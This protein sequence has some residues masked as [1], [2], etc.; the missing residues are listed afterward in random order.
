MY[1]YRILVLADIHGNTKAVSKLLTTIQESKIK[2]D[3][4]LIAGDLPE[5]TPIRLILQ[6]ILTHG[7]LSK[8]KYTH[9]VYKGRGR[10]QF[11][12]A[13]I[14]SVKTILTLLGSLK[15]PIVYIP[16]NVDSYE[17]QRL[18]KTWPNTKI[19]FLCTTRKKFSN[20]QIAG[21][22]GSE[23][24]PIQYNIP[25][26][27]MEFHPNDFYS[28]L[29]PILRKKRDIKKST[30]DILVTHEAPAFQ[31]EIEGKIRKGGSTSI[32]K[33]INHM[34]PRIS[35][36]GHY[37]ELPTIKKWKNTIYLNPGPL[38]CYY[39]SLIDIEGS[40][41]RVSSKKMIPVRNDYKNIIYYYRLLKTKMNNNLVF[42]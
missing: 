19:S 37:H 22:G 27:D 42:I 11:V 18:L 4:I 15:A 7:N 6:Y 13:Q 2:V 28:R 25:L 21:Y 38:T 12:H 33:L 23:F 40:R 35:I 41:V 29:K 10:K 36:F 17:V 24:I 31:Y 34:K 5:T 1:I 26:C 3:L 16:G 20:L 39:F 8:R 30:V 32:S 14:K 9:W